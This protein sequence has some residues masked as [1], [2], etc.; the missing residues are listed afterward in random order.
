MMKRKIR[1]GDLMVGQTQCSL[2]S[3]TMKGGHTVGLVVDVK[4]MGQDDLVTLLLDNEIW[5]YP[6][7]MLKHLDK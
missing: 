7:C 1:V 6:D 2:G 3:L 5:S 4:R